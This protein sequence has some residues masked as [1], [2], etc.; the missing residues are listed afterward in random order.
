MSVRNFDKV[1]APK[2]VAL[3]GAS[4][5]AGTIGGVMVQNLTGAG[6]RG[7]IFLV[8]PKYS[9]INGHKCY[10]T[11]ESLPAPP[12]LAVIA[13]PPQT[14]PDLIG[15]LSKK[16]TRAAVI[17][18][19][20][21]R[22]QQ[23]QTAMLDAAQPY[24]LRIVGPN[25]LGMMVPGMG[26]NASFAHM[27]PKLGGLGFISQSGAVL[28]AVLDWAATREIGF[29]A[30]VSMGDMA[31]VDVGDLLDYFTCD[32]K[33]NAVLMY[34][35]HVTHAR[36]FMS[37]ARSAA[38]I[39][40]VIVIK[41]G[42]HEESAKAAK[43]HT[44]ALAGADHVYDAAFRRAGLVRVTEL[45]DLFDAAEM[46]SH[47][48]LSNGGNL[49]IVTNGGGAGVLAVDRLLDC[50]GS[51]AA[52]SPETL[53][54][55]DAALPPAWSKAN[56]VDIIG[57]A[58]A[59]RYEAAVQAVFE[60]SGVNAVLVINCP[61]ALT[62]STDA[63]AAT[64]RAAKTAGAQKVLLT[65]WLGEKTADA[66][67]KMFSA[68]GISTF[69]TPDD[70]VRA[71]MYLTDHHR[72]Q[73]ALLRTPPAQPLT[74]IDRQKAAH[75]IHDALDKGREY[76]SEWEAKTV[77]AAY[78]VPVVPT[79]TVRR[80]DE[81]LN[82]ARNL[83]TGSVKEIVVKILSP[84]IVHKTDVGGVALNL[85]DPEAAARAAQE[86][87]TRVKKALP[88]A[89]I[90]GFTLQP[91]IRRRNARELILG[92]SEDQ[93]FGPVI[94]FGAGGTAVEVIR[95]RAVA[96]PP[97]DIPLALDLIARTQV[98]RSLKAYRN[99]P[100]ADTEAIARVLVSLSQLIID[101][102]EIHELDINPLLADE[103]GV[104]ALDARII[105]KIAQA[106]LD[107]LNPRFVIRPYPQQWERKE[108]LKNGRNIILRPIR[109][110]DEH[111]YGTFL[112][113]MDKDDLRLRLF[114]QSQTLTHEFIARLTQIDYARAMAFVAL[115][116]ATGELLGVSRLAADP[117]YKRAEFAVIVRSDLK[118]QG[119]GFTLMQRLLDYA[120]TE[121]IG[122]LWACILRENTAMLQMCKEMGFL[123]QQ[124]EAD[125]DLMRASLS[126]STGNHPNQIKNDI[127]V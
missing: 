47:T 58:G 8:N 27:M 124:S 34:L 70:A 21:I 66:A 74:P 75:I 79:F 84:D 9:D 29:S 81:V 80:P 65:S 53:K 102:P 104:L 11:I 73:A 20:G 108:T 52:L 37:A 67:R 72:A 25:C 76:L 23:L 45:E 44:G 98:S 116:P 51:L 112:Q 118:K 4:S 33:T 39:K 59:K 62:S 5:K 61:T 122:E 95:D 106:G 127:A 42:R 69:D 88:A 119:I 90:E 94:L 71:F 78:G 15:R 31:D 83:M 22:E 107:G 26:L 30:M 85:P 105:V 46:L 109:P 63:A 91:M 2:S 10:P 3:I 43:S 16:G 120:R 110:E 24:C 35:E 123:L 113:K 38:R 114:S 19:A 48:R 32:P 7:D 87:F 6:F 50:G 111:L 57:D 68:A 56:P 103:K 126:L 41:A 54:Q 13:T 17:I 40:P 92:V 12:D 86:M 82:A 1:F 36:K 64:I 55:L 99:L 14:I 115:D 89:K 117:D 100:A 77:L 97:L 96:L 49:A 125:R 121:A 93:T 60:D 18:T 101:H 28:G